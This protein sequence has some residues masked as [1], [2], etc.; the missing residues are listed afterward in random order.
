MENTTAA[1]LEQIRAALQREFIERSRKN[2]AYSLRAFAKY[3][4]IDQSFLS[5][6]LKGQ[7]PVTKELAETIGP[8]LGLKPKQIKEIFTAGTVAMPGFIA[9]S[10]DEFE[11]LSEWHHF[12][13]I[14]LAKTEDFH[15]EPQKIAQRLGLH[16]EEVRNALDRL[17]RLSFIKRN[18]GMITVLSSNT[19]WSNTKVTSTARKKFQRTLLE[20]SLDS[21]DHVPFDLRENGSV[22]VAINKS[23]IPEFKEKLK[24]VRK[25]LADFFQA[26]GEKNLDEVYQLTISFYPLT[27][28]KNKKTKTTGDEK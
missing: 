1:N 3:L 6:L 21:L 26:D 24:S 20:K 27:Q 2:P 8:K 18:D 9:L 22:T 14:E 4:E 10:D 17:E 25:E 16:V 12:A 7:R 19:T 11:L 28:I 23:R 13:I 15:H 5:K